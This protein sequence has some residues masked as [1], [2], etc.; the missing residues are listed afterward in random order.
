[1]VGKKKLRSHTVIASEAE[2]MG[3]GGA[4][5]IAG[6]HA[7]RTERGNKTRPQC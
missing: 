3:G 6:V 5:K 4:A 2:E 7:W 1:V